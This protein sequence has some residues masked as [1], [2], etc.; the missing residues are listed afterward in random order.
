MTP[1]EVTDDTLKP[2]VTEPD[3]AATAA[4]Q[5]KRIPRKIAEVEK[6]RTKK[7]SS[8]LQNRKF[9]KQ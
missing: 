8:E 4:V 7:I 9:R 1:L 3:N 5:Q 2:A 6:N